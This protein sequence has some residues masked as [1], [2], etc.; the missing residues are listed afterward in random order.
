MDRLSWLAAIVASMAIA[1]APSSSAAQAPATDPMPLASPHL[2]AA[3]AAA[4]NAAAEIEV[5]T[6]SATGM[7]PKQSDP[8]AAPLLGA[9]FDTAVLRRETPTFADMVALG[10][11][12]SADMKV[13]NLYL[14]AGSGLDNLA[15]LARSATTDVLLSRNI[16]EFATEYGHCLD[17]QLLLTD[18][19]SIVI[20]NRIAV[21]PP[22]A[23]NPVVQ[24]TIGRL[25]SQ[26][27]QTLTAILDLF[28]VPSMTDNWRRDRLT[29]MQLIAPRVAKLLPA[30]DNAAIRKAALDL[31]KT[32]HDQ[33][34]KAR[35][36]QFAAA[37]P[38]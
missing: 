29:V 32:L 17:T 14:T 2:T 18:A 5:L 21:Y 20:T 34:V 37:F 10:N 11:W 25:G 23:T 30:T 1:G 8:A 4:Q 22:A 28:D 19:E 35:L 26:Q 9:L 16:Y 15:L 7:P 27:A 31:S 24:Q 12:L 38:K 3:A 36:A 13:T 33:T 6:K